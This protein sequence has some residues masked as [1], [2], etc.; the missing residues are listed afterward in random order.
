[1]KYVIIAFSLFFYSNISCAAFDECLGVYVGRI[2]VNNQNGIDRVVLIA[3]P[4]DAS[5][6]YWVNFSGWDRDAKKEAM[7]ILLA[8]KASQHRVD[9]YTTDEDRCGIGSTGKTFSEIHISTNP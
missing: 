6:S 2:S 9:I 1:M 4:G 5:G 3:S 8:A 7:S